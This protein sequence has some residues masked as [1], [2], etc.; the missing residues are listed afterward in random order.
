[1]QATELIDA[2]ARSENAAAIV[3][4]AERGSGAA[5]KAARRALNVLRA[6]GVPVPDRPPRVATITRVDEGETQHAWLFPPDASGSALIVIARRAPARRYR[7]VFLI[8]QDERGILRIELQ[9]LSQSQL[10]DAFARAFPV[11]DFKPAEVP[12]EW[13]RY[14]IEQARLCHARSGLP[15]PLG[16]QS[17]AS[18]LQPVPERA[19]EHPFDGEG[20]ELSEEDALEVAQGSERLHALPEFRSWLPEKS[21]VDELLLKVGETLSPGQEPDPEHVQQQ[22]REE[23]AAATDRYFSPQR[24]EQIVHLMKDS[25]ISV[26]SREGEVRALELVGAM[27]LVERAGLITHPPREVPF[28]RAFFD[29]AIALLLAQGGGRLNIPIPRASAPASPVESESSEQG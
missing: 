26:L 15:E 21:A 5:R 9:E 23:I 27:K 12:V 24:R 28:L 18:W 3:E 17:A 11:G 29:K 25:A 19:P 7:T 2:W 10:K 6:R 22:L 14:R 4:V 16:L 8:L 13:A 20:L 1:M